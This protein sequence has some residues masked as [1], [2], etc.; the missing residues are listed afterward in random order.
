MIKQRQLELTAAKNFLLPRLDLV[1]TQRFRG[2]GHD[3]TGGSNTYMD[4]V[5][6]GGGAANSNAFGDL[7]SGDFTEW[8]VGA[9]MSAPIGFRRGHNAV[10]YAELRLQREQS[11][12]NEQQRA[13]SLSLSN[14]I[15]ESRRALSAMQ[16]SERRFQEAS[17]YKKQAN[18]L[19]DQNKVKIDVLLEAERRMLEARTQ[20]I[21]SE[22]EYMIAIKNVHFEKGTLL[23]YNHVYLNEAESDSEAYSSAANRASRR[24]QPTNYVL[25]NP[26]V[27][28]Q[29][30]I[31]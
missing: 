8:Q 24:R 21:R 5:N 14:A 2:L 6:A 20:F 4:D 26:V 31:N 3:L 13:I 9:E 19:L 16:M 25:R 28:A 18:E 23:D 15:G 7:L 29:D 27:T 30:V 12:L 11:M 17:L 1:A 22:A 10:R